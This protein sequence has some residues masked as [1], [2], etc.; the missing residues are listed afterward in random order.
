M[1]GYCEDGKECVCAFD[2]PSTRSSCASWRE[3]T[4]TEQGEHATPE[5]PPPHDPT[6]TLRDEF[7]MAA[8]T[9]MLADPGGSGPPSSWAAASYAL[10]DAM[11]KARAQ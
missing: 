1:A 6:R 8:L 10:A 5:S 3:I 11:L 2:Q 4:S 9:G 7:A